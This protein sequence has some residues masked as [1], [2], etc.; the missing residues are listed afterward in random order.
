MFRYVYADIKRICKRVPFIVLS[1]ILLFVFWITVYTPDGEAEGM[2]TAIDTTRSMIKPVLAVFGGFVAIMFIFGD[3][4]KAKTSQIAIGI[5]ISRRKIVLG[6]WI[7]IVLLTIVCALVIMLG[8]FL[9]DVMSPIEFS[10]KNWLE[11]IGIL[12]MAV[13]SV[14]TYMAFT[15]I[16]IYLTKATVLPLLLYIFLSTGL[17]NKGIG[18]LGYIPIVERMHITSL[19]MTNLLN[20]F[21]SRLVLGY[22]SPL[23]FIGIVIYVVA[24]LILTY[25]I[26]RKQELDF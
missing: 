10:G 11:I 13:L 1:C 6:K 8:V 12:L 4:L 2:I 26:F 7:E 22:F 21:Q 17:I 3:G 19:T 20:T 23:Q 9:A 24:S 5:G 16:L 15:M 25:L 18:F 14:A